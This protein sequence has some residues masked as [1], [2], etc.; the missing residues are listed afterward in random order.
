MR[1]DE[2]IIPIRQQ[3]LYRDN[4]IGLR[5]LDESGRIHFA[6]CEGAHMRISDECWKPLVLKF[7]GDQR[8]EAYD[9]GQLV[10]QG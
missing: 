5:T 9:V 10:V 2:V 1:E 4:R 3:P 7:C 6:T 8:G